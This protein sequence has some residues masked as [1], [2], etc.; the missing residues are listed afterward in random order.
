MLNQQNLRVSEDKTVVADTTDSDDAPI[1]NDAPP[2]GGL[3]A[4]IQVAGCFALYL[5][6]L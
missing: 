2:N 3:V 6:T 1:S 4:W 5:N